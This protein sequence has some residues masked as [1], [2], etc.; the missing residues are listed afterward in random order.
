MSKIEKKYL[1]ALHN[2]INQFEGDDKH[3]AFL[4]E[5]S[6]VEEAFNYIRFELDIKD[7]KFLDLGC[8][9]GN[10]LFSARNILGSSVAVDFNKG[11][12]YGVEHNATYAAAA[13]AIDWRFKIFTTSMFS[14]ISKKLIE[15]VDIIYTYVPFGGQKLFQLYKLISATAKDGAL[16]VLNDPNFK[17]EYFDSK[18]KVELLKRFK[19]SDCCDVTDILIFIKES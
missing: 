17:K 16:I 2:W 3:P 18:T 5:M 10:I 13:N 1:S 14:S 9:T 8:A 15:E 11:A 19:G 4:S 7:P 6:V 12:Y